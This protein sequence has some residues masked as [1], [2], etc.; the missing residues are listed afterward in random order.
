HPALAVVHD[1]CGGETGKYV[2]AE[3]LG[4]TGEPLAKSTE[5]D[6]EVAAIVHRAR[7]ESVGDRYRFRCAGQV[8]NQVSLDRGTDRSAPLAPIREKLVQRARL[9]HISREDMGA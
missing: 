8:V 2:D 9:E 5:A 1:V 7:H 6:N 4:F 3:R